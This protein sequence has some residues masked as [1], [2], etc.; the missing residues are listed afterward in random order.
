VSNAA[1]AAACETAGAQ[2]ARFDCS[3]SAGR[4]SCPGSSSQPSRHPVIEWYLLTD[5]ST[6]AAVPNCRALA[7]GRP[8]LMPW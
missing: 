1:S 2:I 7:Q 6:A 4:R 5:P 3:S 8:K